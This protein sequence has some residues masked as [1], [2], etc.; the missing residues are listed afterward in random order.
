MS[1]ESDILG[2][3]KSSQAFD[4]PLA[5]L[6][7]NTSNNI[8][9]NVSA[10]QANITII[11]NSI[12]PLGVPYPPEFTSTDASNINTVITTTNATIGAMITHTNTLSGSIINGNKNIIALLDLTQTAN[13]ASTTWDK[14]KHINTHPLYESASVFFLKDEMTLLI[15]TNIADL[16]TNL[17]FFNVNPTATIS[18]LTTNVPI[19]SEQQTLIRNKIIDIYVCINNINT[20]LSG[21]LS[22]DNTGW[23]NIQKRVYNKLFSIKLSAYGN[24]NDEIKEYFKHVA[25]PKLKNILKMS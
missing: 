17:S 13:D 22:H 21:I 10:L 16:Y 24:A 20:Y 12:W 5:T 7:I 8:S 18:Y 19:F 14:S 3:L 9:I 2:L 25:S 6:L 4:N 1:T 11:C 23:D 15:N